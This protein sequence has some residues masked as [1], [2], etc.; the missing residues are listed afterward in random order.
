MGE[1]I[2]VEDA[3]SRPL[4]SSWP[5]PLTGSLIGRNEE[6][7]LISEFLDRAARGGDAMFLT[8]E[9]G[10]GKT[11]LLDAAAERAMAAGVRV[12]RAS[13][14]EFEADVLF[15]GLHQLLVPMAEEFE[16]L[17][18]PHRGALN[19]ALGFGSG[20]APDR[21]LVGNATLTLVRNVSM[22]RPLLII[23]DDLH[24]L[25]RATAPVLGFL[26]RR[27]A[28]TAAG[29]L[30]ASRAD[31]GGSFA[32][33]GLAELELRPLDEA[34]AGQ[35]MSVRFP[36]L[37]AR[38]RRRLLA[39]ARGNPLAVLE[40]PRALS[41][42]G[43]A[44]VGGLAAVL[45][46]GRRLQGVYAS[47]LAQIP[48]RSRD[49]LLM[50]ALDGTSDVR[51]LEATGDRQ[52]GLADL[53]PAERAQLVD[54]K[55][56]THWL[57]FRH[58]LIRT[59]VVELSTADERRRAHRRL[60]ELTSAQ[61]DRRA[62]HL[63]EATIEPD[64]EVAALLEHAAHTSLQRGDGIGAVAA[65]IRASELSPAARDRARRLADAAYISANVTGD[66]RHAETLLADA[67][68]ADPAR[69]PSAETAIA[70]SFVLLNGDGDIA[71]A[72]RLLLGAIETADG[73]DISP[74]TAEEA[75]RTLVLVCHFGG[76]AELWESLDR[77]LANF[78]PELPASLHLS[79]ILVADPA[80]SPRAALDRLDAEIE[81]LAHLVD[82][83]E[84]VR[85]AMASTFVDRLPNCRQALR[86]VARDELDGEA[87]TSVIYANILL[88]FEAY[89]TGQWD[90]SRW[91]LEAAT[92]LCDARGYQ[93]LRWNA[94]AVRAF[95]AA[96]R[97][98]A[99]S[100][101]ALADEMIRWAGPRGAR[102]L[103]T[104]A[105]YT[106][107]LAALAQSDFEA[108][109]HHATK[110]SP[111]GQLAPHEPHAAW[112]MMDLVEA[113][114]RT[115]R[116]SEASAHVHAMQEAGVAMV[117]SRLALLSGGA[118]AMIAPDEEAIDLFD[119]SL[120]I[121]EAER[122]PFDLAR[123]HLL[124]GERLRRMRAMTESR[125]HLLAALET[126][127][128]LGATMWAERAAMELRAA[129]QTRPRGAHHG[130]EAL[131]SQEL[132]I[133][134][135][136]ASGMSNK[137][138]GNRLFLSHR[139]VSAH[140]YRVFPKLGITSRAALRDALPHQSAGEPDN[141]PES[142]GWR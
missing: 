37:P 5:Q 95:L 141:S 84:I 58:P 136:A 56:D 62:W 25:D 20:P 26:A 142:L 106:C 96:G 101:Q 130:R 87:V 74:R 17:C 127:R 32:P 134:M 85:I 22:I 66:L 112:V 11:A 69:T 73:R 92:E 41:E 128:R 124:Y 126:F 44:T 12:L 70:A 79:A 109:Y 103:H 123:V 1:T 24:W 34:A 104:H 125:V 51:L 7:A 122:W 10:I 64:E 100:A 94:Q 113:A 48:P 16:H 4:T 98:E 82:S 57:T 47:R 90:E 21:L 110:I 29:F 115:D 39:E 89:L 108:A 132:E 67:R 43:P 131:T 83:A 102:Y 97:G 78:D 38:T 33:T 140:L 28:G 63:G 68:H 107:V 55:P 120:A 54:M 45:P 42:R 111:A 35:L 14:V 53:V 40:L 9:H 36:L 80:R 59:A 3:V 91:L 71:T 23:V 86:R 81:S 8:G 31:A 88:A 77:H 2:L 49:A 27:L 65:L 117:S 15:A 76:R 72:H 129:G 18:D 121:R 50:M 105:L 116:A 19:A 52:R 139:T 114:L 99:A 46:L 30:A 138:I 137:Q 61:P 75:L 118:A 13:G 60:A 119:R 93:L 135:L 6:L 133:A